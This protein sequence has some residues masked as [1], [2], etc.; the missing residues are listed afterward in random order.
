LAV[1]ENNKAQDID[2]LAIVMYVDAAFD[3]RKDHGSQGGYVIVM[4]HHSVLKGNKVPTSTLS[5]RSF[6]LARVCRSSVAAECQALST[7]LDELLL[8]KNF[9][10]H[11]Q[12]PN[13][14]LK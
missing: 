12:Y 7:G 11:L 8:V 9:I 5:W 1:P 14:N 4:G 13:L 2:D 10:T 3:V 6:K